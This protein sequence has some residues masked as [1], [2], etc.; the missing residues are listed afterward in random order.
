MLYYHTGGTWKRRAPKSF[1][2]LTV[3]LVDARGL[4][5]RKFLGNVVTETKDL[6]R[7]RREIS[8]VAEE[9]FGEAYLEDRSAA[10]GDGTVFFI[11]VLLSC[12]GGSP[13]GDS[14]P[15]FPHDIMYIRKALTPRDVRRIQT[16]MKQLDF[17]VFTRLAKENPPQIPTFRWFSTSTSEVDRASSR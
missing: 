17:R 14:D 7:V 10:V 11:W 13:D 9:L 8:R 4:D 5:A 6:I 15:I 12:P 3:E 1:T 2:G 16:R